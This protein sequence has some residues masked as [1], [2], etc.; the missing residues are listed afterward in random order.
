MLKN[1]IKI[2]VLILVFSSCTQYKHLIYLDNV[3]RE[4]FYPKKQETY[5]IHTQ[6]VLYIKIISIDPEINELFSNIKGTA[7]TNLFQNETSLYINGYVVNDSGYVEIPTIGEVFLLNKTLD[8]AKS[9]IEEKASIY[10][11][12]ATIDVKLISFKFTVLGEV[13]NPGVF[14]NYNNQLTVLEAIGMA[15]D[16]TEFG[17]R[18]KIL[19]LRPTKDGTETYR[20]DLTKKD[21]L[22]S[23]AYYLKPNDAVYVE[24]IKSKLFRINTPTYTLFLSSITTLIL[25]LNYVNKGQ[26]NK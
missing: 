11:K 22:T 14:R 24:P 26:E 10:L 19:V 12:N 2:A 21:I 4:D 5:K 23:D 17:N 3:D 1:T 20:I 15:G 13:K 7:Q 18:R 8:E 9:V 6:D 16:I 25:I